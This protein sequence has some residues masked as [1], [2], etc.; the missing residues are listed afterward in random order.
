MVHTY[1]FSRADQESNI[2]H[3]N[4][5]TTHVH[6]FTRAFKKFRIMSIVTFYSNIYSNRTVIF[7]TFGNLLP[8][9]FL[10]T[11]LSC[12]FF[13]QSPPTHLLSC[14]VSSALHSY[15]KLPFSYA[16]FFFPTLL[17]C[18]AF[19]MSQSLLLSLSLSLSLSTLISWRNLSIIAVI[20]TMEF[21][22]WPRW[23]SLDIALG[24]MTERGRVGVAKHWIITF[25]KYC[26]MRTRERKART[27]WVY[28]STQ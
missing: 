17:L 3:S 21:S 8:S 1:L 18:S 12:C 6:R 26:K 24:K 7:F 9:N 16:H 5:I 20:N 2:Q 4:H 11:L 28:F 15:A 25:I 14:S 22:R 23:P 10:L 19:P 13:P 27:R